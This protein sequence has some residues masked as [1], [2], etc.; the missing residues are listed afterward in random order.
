VKISEELYI[1]ISVL[2]AKMLSV[3]IQI[4]H[5]TFKVFCFV[6]FFSKKCDLFFVTEYRGN[7]I[8]KALRVFSSLLRWSDTGR[9][10]VYSW[11]SLSG[12]PSPDA[13]GMT[14]GRGGDT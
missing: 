13:Q 6:L 14:A 8:Q 12:Q 5:R 3:K 11:T 9:A 10:P 2:M 1:Q 7:I 4:V